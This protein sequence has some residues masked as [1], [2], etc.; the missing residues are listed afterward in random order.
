MN[1]LPISGDKIEKQFVEGFIL[2]TAP[3]PDC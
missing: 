1:I 3:K 2:D